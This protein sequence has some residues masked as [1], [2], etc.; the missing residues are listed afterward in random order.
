MNYNK[1]IYILYGVLFSYLVIAAITLMVSYQNTGWDAGLCLKMTDNGY[2]HIPFN[3]YA[4]P[5]PKNLNADQYEFVAWW[6]P[7]QFAIPLLIQ[8][9]FNV[10]LSIALKLLTIFCMLISAVGIF[11][12]YKKLIAKENNIGFDKPLTTTICLAL[13]IFTIAEPF[14]WGNLN[15]YDGGGILMLAYCPWFIYW[16]IKCN[17]VNIYSSIILLVLGIVGFFLKTSFTSIFI[18]SLLYLFLSGS[19]LPFNSFKDRNFKKIIVMGL[20]LGGIFIIYILVIKAAFLDQNRNISNSSLGVRL[21]P[22]VLFYPIVAPL[23]ALFPSD[24][25][26]K[27]YQWIIV[28][29][30]V[31]PA[32]YVLLKNNYISLLYKCIL[33][34]FITTCIGFY[35]LLYLL[36]VDVSYEL[37]H[38]T[39]ITI[40]ITP[41]IF[42]SFR[43]FKF[44]N[45]SIYA[46]M[47]L[48]FIINIANHLKNL[49]AAYKTDISFHT[50]SGL[51]SEYSADLLKKIDSLDNLN[52][53][54][55]DI[56][57]FKNDDP[58][59]A[60]EIRNNRVLFEDNFINF[61]FDNQLR[62]DRTLYFGVNSG[63]IYLI[64]PLR[65]FKKD[66]IFYLTR[67]E[68]YKKFENIYQTDGFG[69]FKAIPTENN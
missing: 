14:F 39:I 28:S 53:K 5:N 21:E 1:A 38:F 48:Y 12:L 56:F 64:Y 25:F 20:Y 7:G 16:I 26:T 35:L 8:K 44:V 40:L 43:K 51:P 57:Y 63:Q 10:K 18:G 6:S 30:F 62:F 4:H 47:T 24:L 13:L 59:I 66:S 67:F 58:S 36:N 17:R 3:Y 42:L 54:R 68:K 45:Y 33:I 46:L 27:T 65:Q 41:A 60:L 55:N 2:K 11:Q 50:F 34:S 19:I 69:I 49:V 52:N 15:Q 23:L 32:Y 61:H 22:R 31:F 37:R 29:L 9:C